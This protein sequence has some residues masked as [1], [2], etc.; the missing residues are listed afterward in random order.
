[1]RMI[2]PTTLLPDPV[3]WRA[4]GNSSA[5]TLARRKRR[6]GSEAAERRE[7]GLDGQHAIRCRSL[8]RLRFQKDRRGAP[9]FPGRPGHAQGG[10]L[11]V[12]GGGGPRRM[13]DQ[14]VQ[15]VR[16]RNADVSPEDLLAAIDDACASVRAAGQ[17][18]RA[19]A[20]GSSSTPTPW[21]AG[22]LVTGD[23]RD[24]PSLGADE[25]VPVITAGALAR[26]LEGGR[27]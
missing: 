1:M 18:A 24:L 20:C 21:R 17:A 13:F 7:A 22:C 3:K 10:H 19:R 14:T 12:R 26:V 15:E 2:Q 4:Q 16:A 25:G 8:D 6:V 11:Q 9:R 27:R 5:H 23:R